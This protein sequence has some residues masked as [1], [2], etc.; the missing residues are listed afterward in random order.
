MSISAL[1][2]LPLL[3]L[4]AGCQLPVPPL[5]LAADTSDAD[6]A[7]PTDPQLGECAEQRPAVERLLT[8]SCAGC[9]DNG[10]TRGGLGNISDLNHLIDAGY[11]VRGDAETSIIYNQVQSKRMP[12][13]GTPLDEAQLTV[14]RDWIDVCTVVEEDAEDVSLA[15]A[16]ACPENSA[17]PLQDQ[18]KAIRDD[19]IRLGDADARA[20]RYLSLAHLY[21]AGYC[22]AQIEGYR[23]ALNKLLNH[24][25]LAPNIQNPQAIDE[26]RTLYRINLFDYG[27]ST[28]TWKSITDRDP[29]A[30]VLQSED[31]LDIRDAAEV[32]LFSI[33]ADWF[34]DAASQ[35]PLYYEI[36][37]IPDT[38]IG[39]EGK[40]G[41]E[42]KLGLNVADNIADELNFDRDRVVRAG[43]QESKV[44]F[45]NR[46][47]ERHELP[48]SPDR[49]YWIS[50][51]FAEAPKGQPLPAI[52][53]IFEEPLAFQQDGGEIIF[54]LANGLQAYMLVDAGGKRIDTGPP[55]VVH[56]LETPEESVV[57]NGLSCISCHSEGMR[58]A[59]DEIAEFVG[60]N[61][62]FDTQ[63]QQD[64]ARLYAPAD[65]FNRLQQHDIA[66]FVAAMNATGAQRLVGGHE[67]VMA[68]HLAF[69]GPVDL[70]RAAAEFGVRESDVLK[71]LAAMRGLS[72]L[73]RVTVT[74]DT[75]Q[76][77]FAFNASCV[78]KLA[79]CP[80]GQ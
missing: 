10:N 59:T 72:T 80:D 53:N 14:L 6:P 15:E 5:D 47:V 37:E 7:V 61:P 75:F 30:L 77:N 25:S 66:T 29:Y 79:V 71:N 39:L 27:W 34:I 33:K 56:D 23:H 76:A 63:E 9:H 31:A 46:I 58:L 28:A 21:G 16:P 54:N 4:L 68:A 52:K 43:F 3:P 73:D 36:L 50:Y 55:N 17:V 78:L 74:R 35:P 49:A 69:A 64:V 2:A 12:Q 57:I 13:G 19:I 44:S 38:L 70:R 11:V 65:V 41:L 20:T 62:D 45:S 51:D 48:S 67:P 24:L 40:L 42:D 1:R 26:A 18:L 32:D 8:D 22:E 60:G